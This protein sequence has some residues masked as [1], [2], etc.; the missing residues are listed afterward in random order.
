M[1]RAR[2]NFLVCSRAGRTTPQRPPWAL[3]EADFVQ[4]CLRCDRCAVHC[5][6]KIIVRGQGGFPEIDFSRGAC[7]FCGVCAQACGSGALSAAGQPWSLRA[8][9]GED[10]ITHSGVVCRSCGD[11]C[12]VRAITFPPRHRDAA[13]P[14]VNTETCNGCGA[15][16]AA[17]PMAT[18]SMHATT[19]AT[20]A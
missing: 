10:C 14:V 5:P 2:R 15:C 12:D 7:T 9:I 11:A 8:A 20:A 13:A 4:H 16:F 3:E 19:A 17:C 18:I 1:D 6:P